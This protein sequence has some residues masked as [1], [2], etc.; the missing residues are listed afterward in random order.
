MLS[1]AEFEARYGDE[2]S[3]LEA[4]TRH[5]SGGPARRRWPWQRRAAANASAGKA[6]T[7]D[8][9]TPQ[10]PEQLVVLYRHACEHLALARSRRYPAHLVQRLEWLTGE[11]H[12][13][14]YGQAALG[15]R[16]LRDIVAVET[17]QRFRALAPWMLVAAAAFV[18]PLL[19]LGVAC[20]LDPAFALHVMDA[21]TLRQYEAMYDSSQPTIGP[22]RDA[23]DDWTMFGFYVMN[24]IG[25]AFQCFASG[26]L[27]G[28]GSLYY[29]VSNGVLI[30]ATAGYLTARGHGGPFW[31][32]VATHSAFELTAIV[33]AG[34]AGLRVGH[35]LLWPGRLSRQQALVR[36]GQDA[37][38]AVGLALAMLAIA[39]FIEAFWSSAGW[40][41]A[42]VKFGVAALCWVLVMHYLLRQGR[43]RRAWGDTP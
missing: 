43:P 6:P 38:W 31:S 27:A 19:L 33:I 1:A 11:A 26:L 7:F 36:A 16:R 12:A 9:D 35:G 2:W 5:P 24:N 40:I 42:P 18:L 29:L 3:A 20:L 15:G 39:A 37:V 10:D 23:G 8:G 21:P 34:G 30:G 25:I 4:W 14:V 28:I 22:Q 32:F 41:A 13:L 17:P